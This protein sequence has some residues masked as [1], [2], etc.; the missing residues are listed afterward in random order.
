LGD[1]IS[2]EG[3]SWA[4]Y[5]KDLGIKHGSL[6]FNMLFPW[7]MIAIPAIFFPQKLNFYLGAFLT[8]PTA[9]WFAFW[10]N[11]YNLH[12][13]EAS[14]Y[15]LHPN[16]FIN[17]LL[18]TIFLTPFVGMPI[19]SYRISHSQHHRFLG[20]LE[21]TEIS[22]R[23]SISYKN[24][25]E[26]L[27]GIYLLRMLRKYFVNFQGN[28][29]RQSDV[30]NSSLIFVGTLAFMLTIQFSIIF[31]LSWGISLFLGIAWAISFFM[32]APL[33]GKARQT[34]EHRSFT[35]RKNIDYSKVV[36]GPQNRIFGNDFFSR[37]FG[38]AGFNS[39]LLH[40]LDPTVSYTRFPEMESF[41]LRTPLRDSIDANRLTYYA[42][43]KKLLLND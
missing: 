37:F 18:A 29:P 9:I 43:F 14:H 38:A 33:I 20:G 27:I 12:F 32:I 40:H 34:L 26:G 1:L 8:I 25:L 23:S 28:Y 41:M 39:H 42:T 6:L 30:K 15:N 35:A 24:L 10:L 3:I 36:H 4:K 17:D 19:G 31:L 16:K 5:K 21:D 13:H 2:I 7:I 11:A 22:Y